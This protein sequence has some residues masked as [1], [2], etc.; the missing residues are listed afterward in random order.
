M[1]KNQSKPKNYRFKYKRKEPLDTEGLARVL[2][3]MA[4]ELPSDYQ[5]EFVKEAE[6]II[7]RLEAQEKRAA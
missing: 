2:V 7:R 3:E 1:K 5:A 4:S 6:A